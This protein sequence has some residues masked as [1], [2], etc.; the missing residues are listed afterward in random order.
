[1]TNTTGNKKT[2]GEEPKEEEILFR[3]ALELE[4]KHS[5]GE[6]AELY[7]AALEKNPGHLP[8]LINLASIY[9][10]S[11]RLSDAFELLSP[12]KASPV[13]EV[14][15]ALGNI[16]TASGRA[17][18]ALSEYD[19]ALSISPGKTR[20]IANK[21]LTTNYI[22]N[23]SPSDIFK[24]HSEAGR[25]I[26]N[27]VKRLEVN[28]K[29]E[30]KIR[31]GF[32]S[33]DLKRH[34]V[35]FFLE[36]VLAL[37]DKERFDLFLYSDTANCDTITDR[38]KTYGTWRDITLLSDIKSAE[39]ITKDSIDILIDLSGHTGMRMGLFAIKPAPLQVSWLG[40]PNT[41]GLSAIDWRICDEWTDPA[42]Q[43]ALH[44]EKLLRIPGGFQ[45]YAP[46]E[47][48]PSPSTTPYLKN[49]YITFGSF[50]SLPK[51]NKSVVEVWARILKGVPGSKLF[52]KARGLV[53]CGVKNYFSEL[54]LN[55]GI[56]KERL[57][58]SDMK[59]TLNE[60]LSEY[61][62]IDIALDPFPYN[63]ATTS[64]E[65]LWM[66]VPVITLAGERHAG[67]VGVSILKRLGLESFITETKSS[68]IAAART[69]AQNP[70]LLQELRK[71][72]RNLMA[73]SQLCDAKSF[74]KKFEEALISVYPRSQV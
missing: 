43:E 32:V 40:Y 23:L 15:E 59:G 11:G 61:S 25:T 54:F 52:L 55:E 58:L 53:D 70:G 46:P 74:T 67:R 68:Y 27:S 13:S 24:I 63:G 21:L 12:L 50:N 66:G 31:I 28:T 5:L 16:L 36:P 34:S 64:C 7:R 41:T 65:A 37:L 22:A 39:L 33:G 47:D 4:K 9:K 42:G 20:L 6:A 17:E 38:I 30:G 26:E 2:F 60:H 35:T 72:L 44:S 57:I 69:A 62:K 51:I 19:R 1:M 3:A 71:N 49:N 56:E 48:A 18:E 14:H 10:S 8:S 73:S 29:P 45:V